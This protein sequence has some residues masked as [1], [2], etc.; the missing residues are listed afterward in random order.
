MEIKKPENFNDILELQKLLDK[1]IHSTRPRTLEDIKKS[2]I[3]EC[4]EFDEE[5]PQSHKT[6][7]TKPYDKAKELEELTDIWFFVAQLINYC[8]DNSNLSI[9]QKENLN[10]F[11]N[12]HTSSYTESISILDIIFYL[13]G[14]RT[15]Y[16][17]IKFL[18]IDLMILTNGYCYTKD[19]I[20][21]CYWEKWQKNMSRI[22]KEWN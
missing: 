10:R 21:N 6:W 5:T 16:D 22:G 1:S 8:N 11:F 4:I 2:I 13:K 18:I 14:R 20:L 3:A 19:D 7:K 15:D 17:Y 9:L 12:D